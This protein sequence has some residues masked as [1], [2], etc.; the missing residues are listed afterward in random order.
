[1]VGKNE[2]KDKKLATENSQ[3]KRRHTEKGELTGLQT[4]IDFRAFCCQY[5]I[6]HYLRISQYQLYLKVVLDYT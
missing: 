4:S 5:Y 3:L 6:S 2:F 1:V